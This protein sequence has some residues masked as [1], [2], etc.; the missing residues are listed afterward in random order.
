VKVLLFISFLVIRQLVIARLPVAVD[1]TN[2]QRLPR[3]YKLKNQFFLRRLI[4]VEDCYNLL[5]LV[6]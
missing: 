4:E 1:S 2:E 6:S 3:A 5:A